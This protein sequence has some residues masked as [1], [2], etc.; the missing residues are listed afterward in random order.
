MT[1][2]TSSLWGIV[3]AGG[4]GEHL[5]RPDTSSGAI[6]ARRSGFSTRSM[7]SGCHGRSQPESTVTIWP[8]QRSVSTD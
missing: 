2:T 1:A 5:I 7:N 8:F 3:L 6:G 4:E